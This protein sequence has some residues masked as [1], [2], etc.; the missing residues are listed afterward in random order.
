MKIAVT[1]ATGFV[2]RSL[3]EALK[4]RG[5]EVVTIGR[6]SGSSVKWDVEAEKL[7]A[8]ALEGCDAV[9][10]LAGENIAAARWTPEQKDRIRDSR[11]RGTALLAR[12]L[13]S[14]EKKPGQ[15]ISA[16]ATGFYGLNDGSAAFDED[17][18]VGSDFL[19]GVCRDWEAA[20]D[21]ARDAN[22]RTV[23]LRIGVVLG[24]DGGAIGKM[25]VP[26]KLGLGGNIADGRQVMSW[27]SRTDLVAAILHILDTPDLSGPFNAVAPAPASNAQF[28]KAMGQVLKRPTI[29]PMP[30][31]A[32]RLAFGAEMADAILIRGARVASKKLQESGF[33]FKHSDVTDAL[34]DELS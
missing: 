11:V 19:A 9:V 1:G 21:P 34:R 10:H 25:I 26:F 29:F 2:G 15:F 7:D 31:F 14:L 13:A 12:T 27:I 33:T 30:A 20:A 32:A 8:S 17:S 23:H 3:V 4:S 18:P 6:G 24:P 16:S 28:T 22:I 5:S